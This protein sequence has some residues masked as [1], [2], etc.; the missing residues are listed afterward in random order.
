MFN[1]LLDHSGHKGMY[2]EGLVIADV[3]RALW[4]GEI[5]RD[6]VD[7]LWKKFGLSLPMP[8]DYEEVATLMNKALHDMHAS[9]NASAGARRGI[10]YEEFSRCIQKN[11]LISMDDMQRMKACAARSILG[12]EVK[13]ADVPTRAKVLLVRLK[14][15]HGLRA[16]PDSDPLTGASAEAQAAV[17][18][19]CDPSVILSLRCATG[20]ETDRAYGRQVKKS[21][22]HGGVAGR[23]IFDVSPHCD[24][25]SIDHSRH[26]SFVAPPS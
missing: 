23:L 14:E 6:V 12:Q 2:M 19:P 22:V 20:G 26:H 11:R 18:S 8:N 24:L 16:P 1:A 15:V 13:A 25:L 9:V 4:H 7:D 21:S 3:K 10:S 5:P 17:C